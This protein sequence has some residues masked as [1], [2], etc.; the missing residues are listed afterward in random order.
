MPDA[1]CPSVPT[2]SL[3]PTT[4]PASF[5]NGSYTVQFWLEGRYLL[6]QACPALK[7]PVNPTRPSVRP[8][9]GCTDQPFQELEKNPRALQG[10]QMPWLQPGPCSRRT[11]KP[12]KGTPAWQSSISPAL[13]PVGPGGFPTILFLASR[14][15]TYLRTVRQTPVNHSYTW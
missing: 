2:E 7:A 6:Y 3:P 5:L 14:S 9:H 13:A 1:A 4:T 10:H 12:P 15:S 8:A 11:L